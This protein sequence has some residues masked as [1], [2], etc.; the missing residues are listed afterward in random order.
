MALRT[1]EELEALLGADA[2]ACRDLRELWTLAEGAFVAIVCRFWSER[3][4][5]S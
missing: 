1:I 4:Q 2:D 5:R 3:A